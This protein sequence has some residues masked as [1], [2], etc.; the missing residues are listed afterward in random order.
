[1]AQLADY[2]VFT[3][4]GIDGDPGNDFKKIRVG[5]VYQVKYDGRHKA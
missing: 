4:K 1:M 2:A 5:L 3:D